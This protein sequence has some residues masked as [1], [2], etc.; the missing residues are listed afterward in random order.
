[1]ESACRL[2]ETGVA[3]APTCHPPDLKKG[4]RTPKGRRV[5]RPLREQLAETETF[6]RASGKPEFA[7]AVKTILAPHGWAI[8]RDSAPL[9][10]ESAQLPITLSS[11]AKALFQDSAR[12][13]DTSL[14]DLAG[15]A[16]EKV[17]T[18][19][20]LP[21][22]VTKSAPGSVKD[23]KTTLTVRVPTDKLSAVRERLPELKA[24][25]GYRVTL[26]SII[27]GWMSE[28]LGIDQASFRKPL[29]AGKHLLKMT[30]YKS[31]RDHWQEAAA[32]AGLDVSGVVNEGIADL[33]S[34]TWALQRPEL[35]PKGS[36]VG[37]PVG[38]L[39]LWLDAG[40]WE[41]LVEAA[42]RLS[43]E[44]G[45]VMDP[46]KVIVELLKRRLGTPAGSD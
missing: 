15:Q 4:W 10:A 45:Y 22:P 27:V 1:M 44:L 31:L 26:A 17:L 35:A 34:G 36:R 13:F 24:R 16:L 9:A 12:A 46:G 25:A 20:W 42:P 18:S 21:E 40:L 29:S 19:D 11:Q 3:N 30:P 6:L 14:N 23:S 28:E 39:T 37:E 8:L 32:G 7:H 43:R 38:K 33:R 2:E 41:W 5:T